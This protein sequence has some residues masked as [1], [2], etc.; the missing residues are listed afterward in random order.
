MTDS[1][2]LDAAEHPTS[3]PPSAYRIT[4]HEV[5]ALLSFKTGPGTALTRRVL[6]L[7]DLP[8]DH[9]LIRAGVGTLNIRDT[10]EYV[11]GEVS[12]LGE[13]Q[14]LATIFGTSS[15]WY[16]ITRIGPQSVT[17]SYLVRSDAGN[18]AIFLLPMSEYLCVP[19]R[20][21]VDLLELVESTVDEAA[22]AMAGVPGGIVTSRRYHRD[23]DKLTVANL[24]INA[25][26]SVELAS[27]PLDT[28]GQ[29]TV[30]VL[31]SEER[32][33]HVICTLLAAG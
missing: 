29:L 3:L 21:D 10:A 1:S 19:L 9:D 6:G 4:S 22:Q 20:E 28:A 13:A 2:G 24:K 12:L 26:G 27:A 25:T 33:G 30:R 31:G 11:N 16:D 23:F 7:A 18:A 5:L 14:I 15:E 8:D 17:P 32:P